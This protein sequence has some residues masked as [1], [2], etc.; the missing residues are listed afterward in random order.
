MERKN[1]TIYTDSFTVL[2][3][4]AG[5]FPATNNQ[6]LSALARART[7]QISETRRKLFTNDSAIAF[8]SATCISLLT[9]DGRVIAASLTL[10]T[11][12]ACCTPGERCRV[13]RWL[14]RLL[15]KTDKTTIPNIAMASSPATRDTALLIHEALP[16]WLCSTAPMI[17]V[18]SG[19]TVMVMPRPITTTAG[20]KVI[21]KLLGPLVMPG[22][23]KR[24]KPSAVMTGPTTS[25]SFAPK[26]FTKPPAQRE[27]RNMIRL[28]GTKA[29]PAKVGVYPWT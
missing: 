25:G 26:R 29:A 24:V 1:E 27:S 4:G 23:A 11:S 2:P 22:T 17:A 21:Q 12:I 7:V 16:A 14:S 19:A 8:L 9:F 10:C 5:F 18:V 28:N 3:T 20:K 6:A 15:V 13:A